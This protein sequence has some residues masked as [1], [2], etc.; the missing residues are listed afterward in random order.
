MC[1]GGRLNTL[2]GVILR[3]MLSISTAWRVHKYV[4]K[5]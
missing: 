3:K 2:E 5:L 4:V 1:G